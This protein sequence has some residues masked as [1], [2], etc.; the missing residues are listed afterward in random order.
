MYR[1]ATR[2]NTFVKNRNLYS[3]GCELNKDSLLIHLLQW[4]FATC[5]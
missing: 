5:D 4:N 2:D 1:L 3:I